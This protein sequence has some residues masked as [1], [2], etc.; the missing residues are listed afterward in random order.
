MGKKSAAGWAISLC[1]RMLYKPSAPLHK[2]FSKLKYTKEGELV[3]YGVASSR[4]RS[5]L[6]QIDL[7]SA[8][9]VRFVL[10]SL[11]SRPGVGFRL[12]H[13]HIVVVHLVGDRRQ[14]CS[15]NPQ[16]RSR[17]RQLDYLGCTHEPIWRPTTNMGYAVQLAVSI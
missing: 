4:F 7:C 5:A 8:V 3:F 11:V 2:P 13:G 16:I 6:R 1:Q 9:L 12:A 14:S 17:I 15:S 10:R